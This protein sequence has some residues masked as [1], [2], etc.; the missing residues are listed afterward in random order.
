MKKVDLQLFFRRILFGMTDS[1]ELKNIAP[2]IASHNYRHLR[3]CSGLFA[4]LLA[5]FITTA[6]CLPALERF[7]PIY[8][9]AFLF[10][11]S[12]YLLLRFVFKN[13]DEGL[14]TLILFYLMLILAYAFG[15]AIETM[16]NGNIA[17]A[18]NVFLV[19]LPMFICDSPYRIN[20]LLVIAAAI[21]LCVS[22][23]VKS[24]FNFQ[25]DFLNTVSFLLISI[26]INTNNQINRM[27]DFANRNI[28]KIQRDTDP[29]SG[30]MTKTAFEA[31]TRNAIKNSN[32]SG[33]LLVMDI[34]NFKN[35]N[36]MFGLSL[37]DFF[38]ANTG[39]CLLDCCRESDFV[40]RYGGD[41]F[42]VYMSGMVSKSNVENKAA[43]FMQVLKTFFK[44][45]T[46]YGDFSV[47][48]GAALFKPGS[49]ND[50]AELFDQA[51]HALYIAKNSGKDKC[52]I[53]GE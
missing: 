25:F 31:N 18:F 27:E 40:G 28:I 46:K 13:A 26:C 42:L 51:D 2:L 16:L 23:H 44:N 53:Y 35:I 8:F 20:I 49:N 7:L 10:C 4:S 37:G 15:T 47:S 32:G 33:A 24:G 6:I 1:K 52:V 36:D 50:F 17:V 48:I 22:H 38:I 45:N 30:T 39:T 12:E 3:F 43:E 14:P 29:L 21:F 34:D 9:V 11:T 5:L 19:L 41:E